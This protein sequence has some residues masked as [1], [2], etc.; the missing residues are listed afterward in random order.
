VIVRPGSS[1]TISVTKLSRHHRVSY[2]AVLILGIGQQQPVTFAHVDR[3]ADGRQV[4]L[5]ADAG[6]PLIGPVFSTGSRS[7]T[8]S[9]I[10]AAG[11]LLATR[12]AGPL[13]GDVASAAPRL[14][15]SARSLLRGNARLSLTGQGTFAANGFA[16]TVNSTIVLHLG[17]PIGQNQSSSGSAFP[18]GTKVQKMRSVTETLSLVRAGSSLAAAVNGTAD[19]NIC[20]LLDSCGVHGTFALAPNLRGADALLTAT[21]PTTRPLR[22]FLKALGLRRGGRISGIDVSGGIYWSKSGSVAEDLTQSGTCADRAPLGPGGVNLI[23]QGASVL[24]SYSVFSGALRTRCPGPL[25]GTSDGTLASATFARRLLARRTFTIELLP[26]RSFEDDGFFG[27]LSGRLS[28][29]IRTH[30]RLS[31]QVFTEPVG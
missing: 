4:G 23:V 12:C 9:M 21:G 17:R 30:G 11:A 26:A 24:S 10:D 8:L 1:A 3:S 31:Q 15:I 22:D 5:R 28:L 2:Q 29:T 6:Q 27:S 20:E 13:D 19:P 7:L 25:L 18:K 14:R 16:G